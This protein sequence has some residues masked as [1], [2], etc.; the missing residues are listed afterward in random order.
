MRMSQDEKSK[1][2]ARIVASASRLMRE[3]G[4]EGASVADVMKHAG[5]THGGFYKH[6]DTKDALVER[7]LE[8]AFEAFIGSLEEAE[9]E[10]TLATFRAL[11]LSA[12]HKAQPA[13]GCPIAAL[14]SEIA[15]S[16]R[17]VK[18][19]FG[20]GVRRVVEALAK[21]REG[22]VTARRTAALRDLSMVVGAMII[23]RASDEDLAE[24]V[25]IACGGDPSNV[26]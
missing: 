2:H 25:L 7:A 4:V 21:G 20:A 5:M 6:F 24:E 8:S 14:G 10:T 19:A 15:R 1:S 17:S 12:E 9:A 23:A 11:Y 3:R 13:M 16:S 22:S 26:R 18:T